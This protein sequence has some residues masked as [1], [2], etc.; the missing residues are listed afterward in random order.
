MSFTTGEVLQHF[1]EET[2]GVTDA[3]V[4]DVLVGRELRNL[5]RGRDYYIHVRKAPSVRA[6]EN[7]AARARWQTA[8]LSLAK[9][10]PP[11]PHCGDNVTR[12]ENSSH[13]G[14]PPV[15]C[16]PKCM[17][18][19]KRARYMAKKRREAGVTT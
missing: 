12:G 8:R 6:K 11:C 3:A 19:A 7:A 4:D 18:A 1:Y 9:P 5:L 14:K 13:G 2:Q 17:R 15:Y 16:R 10:R